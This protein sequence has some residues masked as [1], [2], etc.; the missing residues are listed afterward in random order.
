ML[1]IED[2]RRDSA[3]LRYV[4]PV[5]S[6]RAGGVSIGIN[7]NVNNAC[8]WAC[9]YCQVEGLTRGGPPPVDL[10]LLAAELGGF[11]DPVQLAGF[12]ARAVPADARQLVDVAFSGNGEPTSAPEFPQAVRLVREVL[13]QCGVADSL[14]VR[15]ITNGS[16]LHRAGVR[17]GIRTLGEMGGE[18]WFKLDRALPAE[19]AAINGVPLDVAKVRRDLAACAQLAK[20]WVQTCWFA[21]DGMAP[22]PASRAAYLAQ[23]APFAGKLAGVHLYGLARPSLQPTAA[24]LQRLPEAELEAF[25][26]EIRRE[27]GIR[28]VVSP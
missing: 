23:L 13:A 22:G 4:Y 6:R 10:D 25:G 8:N 28:V 12:M 20:T 5:V 17:E 27:T 1:T 24:R 26:E 18:V 14:P 15:L 7:L 19:I 16:L 9:V 3:G 11:L 21:L 2:H